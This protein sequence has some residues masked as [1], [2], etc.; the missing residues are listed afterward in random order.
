MLAIILLSK[1]RTLIRFLASK[2]HKARAN[3]HHNGHRG[4]AAILHHALGRF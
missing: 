1:P 3:G 2:E 4:P